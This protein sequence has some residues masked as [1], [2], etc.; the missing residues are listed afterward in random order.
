MVLHEVPLHEEVLLHEALL[1]EVTWGTARL[2][3]GLRGRL[4]GARALCSLRWR[5]CFGAGAA[6]SAVASHHAAE[7]LGNA[8]GAVAVAPWQTSRAT[9]RWRVAW[10][11]GGEQDDGSRKQIRFTCIQVP[12][13]LDMSSLTNHC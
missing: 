5:R 10:A 9:L 13:I 4:L 8:R 6:G 12:Q 1:H 11:A 3:P 7:G 2:S